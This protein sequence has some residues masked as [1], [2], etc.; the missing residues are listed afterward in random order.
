MTE[1]SAAET[2]DGGLA[3]EEAAVTRRAIAVDVAIVGGGPAGLAAAIELRRL[4]VASVTVLERESEVGGIARH[5]EHLGYGTRDL[6]RVLRG[7]D[8]AKRCAAAADRAGVDVR[9]RTTVIDGL[10]TGSLR[11]ATNDGEVRLEATAMLLATGTRE[12]PRSARLVPGSRPA[13]VLTTGSLQQLV[14]LHDQRP[15]SVAVVIGAEHVSFSAVLTLLDA[16]CRVAAIVTGLAHHQT[17]RSLRWATAGRHRVP[18][19]TGVSVAEIVGSPRVT[20][21]K[22]SD[23]TTIA[24]DTVVFTGE[25]RPE[26]ELA[27]IAG[28][29]LDEG[30]GG[31]AVDASLRT[32]VPG[33]F[34]A[35]NVVHGAETADRCALDGRHA[36]RAID[37]WLVARTW[38]DHWAPMIPQGNVAWAHPNVVREG[39]GQ[40]PGDR[41]VLRVRAFDRSPRIAVRQGL[42]E[43]WSGPPRG[44]L[45]PNRRITIPAAWLRRA[46]PS[47]APITVTVEG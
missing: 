40:P 7:P 9:T 29:R 41:I 19:R 44:K 32:S 12:R 42:R 34:C 1:R 24:C 35:G 17:Y 43:L 20:A 10:G 14:A 30:T 33:V 3:T 27:R 22:L 46:D 37:R 11:L 16:G 18:V 8:Y 38:P 31:P 45:V 47:G 13:G 5:S 26:H 28:V 23:G 39:A 2:T 36:A 4:G 6:H 25:W 21:V 15:G